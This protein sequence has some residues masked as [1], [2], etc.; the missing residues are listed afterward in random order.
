MA[1][2]AAAIV[3]VAAASPASAGIEGPCNGRATIAGKTY[4]PA[5]DTPS[6]PIVVPNQPGLLADWEGTTSVVIT[7]HKGKIGLV[8]GS[9]VI[10][11]ASWGSENEDR[12]TSATGLYPIDDF[13]AKLPI[14][15]VGLYVLAGEHKGEGGTCT[16]MVMVKIE[17]NPLGSPVGIASLVGTVLALIGVIASAVAKGGG[18][19]GAGGG[20]GP[21]AAGGPGP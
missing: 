18:G 10:G 2:A 15:I 20:W 3:V 5:N 17:G 7:H 9:A 1:A 4:T 13:W 12:D 11:I 19:T 6:N 8:L 14:D 21:P 16:G